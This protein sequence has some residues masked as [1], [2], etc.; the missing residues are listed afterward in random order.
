MRKIRAPRSSPAAW[1]A[2][3]PEWLRPVLVQPYFTPTDDAAWWEWAGRWNGSY[4]SLKYYIEDP[5]T[6]DSLR[7]RAIL[8]MVVPSFKDFPFHLPWPD[9]HLVTPIYGPEYGL[10]FAFEGDVENSFLG[11][12]CQWLRDVPQMAEL[13]AKLVV[14]VAAYVKYGGF[15]DGTER[16]LAQ[17]GLNEYC[18]TLLPLLPPGS[19]ARQVLEI[20]DPGVSFLNRRFGLPRWNYLGAYAEFLEALRIADSWKQ[21]LDQNIRAR[22]IRDPQ[23]ASEY[24]AI[25]GHGAAFHLWSDELLAQQLDV[26]L[27]LKCRIRPVWAYHLDR[28]VAQEHPGLCDELAH[29]M[30]LGPHA[31]TN[32]RLWTSGAALHLLEKYRHRYRGNP[33]M[34]SVIYPLEAAA[35]AWQHTGSWYWESQITLRSKAR[36]QLLRRTRWYWRLEDSYRDLRL[37]FLYLCE[38]RLLLHRERLLRLQKF[39]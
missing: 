16:T 33:R 8:L 32:P 31:V 17:D 22:V 37:H 11:R 6:P 4:K 13:V 1:T 34:A 21:L 24:A 26:V 9:Q 18:L 35:S 38:D 23:V 39:P 25:I 2:A 29:H 27:R 12:T 3:A 10:H 36:D 30:L 20:Y 19:L 14:H 7:A 28:R 5:A 15:F